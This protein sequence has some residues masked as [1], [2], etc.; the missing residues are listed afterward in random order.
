ML[1][2]TTC[3]WCNTP[4]T[5]KGR[6]LFTDVIISVCSDHADWVKVTQH[7]CINC[8]LFTDPNYSLC[9]FCDDTD[10]DEF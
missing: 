4:A 6:K 9:L 5:V 2:L 3:E 7:K 8:D 10:I 1:T